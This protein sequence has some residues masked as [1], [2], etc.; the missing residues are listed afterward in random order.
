METD[1]T[2][3][4]QHSEA[5][6]GRLSR[7]AAAPQRSP[8]PTV[9]RRRDP[10]L[11]DD[12][13]HVGPWDPFELHPRPNAHPAAVQRSERI[14]RAVRIDVIVSH[15]RQGRIDPAFDGGKAVGV[16]SRTVRLDY[17]PR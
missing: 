9:G 8:R 3:D 11:R 14:G 10:H 1:R 2:D 4:E 15:E 6:Y 7:R 12:P 17:I 16:V 13:G 5:R